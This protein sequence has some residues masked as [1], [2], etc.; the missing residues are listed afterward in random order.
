MNNNKTVRVWDLGVRIFHWSLVVLFVVAYFT[1]DEE[2]I[3]HIYSGYA[4]LALIVFRVVWGF[5]GSRYARF[6]DFVYSPRTVIQY[7]RGIVAGNPEHYL[8]H[9]PLGGWM[10]V[11]LLAA[12]VVVTVTGLK[13]YALEEGRGPLAGSHQTLMID[14]VYADEDENENEGYEGRNQGHDNGKDAEEEM[15][16]ALH[17]ISTD[18]TLFLIFLHILGVVVSSRLHGENLVKAMVTG[19]KEGKI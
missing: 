13:I 16:E 11:A 5:V 12:L 4:V 9:N 8:G 7:L 3:M 15:W 18:I 14:N 17:E 1:A 6:S 10:T 2:N 19:Y